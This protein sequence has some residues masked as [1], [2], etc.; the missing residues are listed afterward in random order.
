[1]GPAFPAE[2]TMPEMTMPETPMPEVRTLENPAPA[3]R[4]SFLSEAICYRLSEKAERVRWRMEDVPWAEI[5]PGTVSPEWLELIRQSA[6]SELTTFTAS[7][8]FLK[9]F[10]DDADFSQWVSVWF[11]E[12]MRHPQALL[13][14][15]GHFGVT[16][17]AE[18]ML[19]GRGTA[20]FMKSRMG[21]LVSNIISEMVA[22]TNYHSLHVHSPEP[23]LAGIALNLSNDEARHASS[24]YAYAKIHL[25]RSQN[26]ERDRRDALK[27][28]YLW[29]QDN[30]R[31]KHPVNEFLGRQAASSADGSYLRHAQQVFGAV[32]LRAC[33]RIGKL[34]GLAIATPEDVLRHL[35]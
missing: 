4:K 22:A 25:A 23:V 2:L 1:M 12:E 34:V 16:V 13:K 3:A 11:Y 20:P 33:K 7:Q 15:L 19:Q 27:V 10:W 31:V 32:K 28:L 35:G 17:D 5:K 14:W 30:D 8:R 26:P 9:D 21:T 24:F 29:F 18:F 6:Y